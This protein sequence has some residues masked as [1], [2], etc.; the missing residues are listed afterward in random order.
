VKGKQSTLWSRGGG[1]VLG[2]FMSGKKTCHHKKSIRL[3]LQTM[4]R[5]QPEK[6]WSRGIPGQ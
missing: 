4:K 1:V 6:G 3:V 2:E 5:G